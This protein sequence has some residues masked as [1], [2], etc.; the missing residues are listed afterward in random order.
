MKPVLRFVTGM[1]VLFCRIATGTFE[2]IWSRHFA[3]SNSI[4]DSFLSFD[5]LRILQFIFMKPF[6]VRFLAFIT[7]VIFLRAK[8]VADF[9]VRIK[10]IFSSS[11]FTKFRNWSDLFAVRTSFRY[12][13]LSHFR[14]LIRRFWLEPVAARTA[15]GS[16]YYISKSRFVK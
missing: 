6:A 14:L 2:R 4:I 7:L 16:S 10:P 3:C 9:T 11:I 5:L 12:T 1:M 13:L 15:V 8:L